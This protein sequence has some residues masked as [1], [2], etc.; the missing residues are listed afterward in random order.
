MLDTERPFVA[1]QTQLSLEARGAKR[2]RKEQSDN[3]GAAGAAKETVPAAARTAASSGAS[4]AGQG[5]K[6]TAQAATLNTIVATYGSKQS[7]CQQVQGTSKKL[8]VAI[9]ERQSSNHKALMNELMHML[10]GSRMT[11]EEVQAARNDLLR[12]ASASE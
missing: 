7:Y 12:R 4:A 2:Q 8:I 9:S 3:G 1:P 11:K 5:L 6:R 10:E